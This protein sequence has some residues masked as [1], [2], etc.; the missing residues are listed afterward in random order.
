MSIETEK[1]ILIVHMN[2]RYADVAQVF[3]LLFERN[4][5]DCPFKVIY[6]YSPSMFGNFN[7]DKYESKEGTLGDDVYKIMQLYHAD[8]C[9]S[10]LGDAFITDKVDTQQF[11]Q[12]IRKLISRNF[13]Y[14]RLY[15][16]SNRTKKLANIR[17]IELYGISFIAFMCS[18]DFAYNELK[19][20]TDLDVEKKYIL[21]ARKSRCTQDV[22]RD[23]YA[24]PNTSLSIEHGIVKGKWAR[25]VYKDINRTV[26]IQTI[27]GGGQQHSCMSIVEELIY[28][29][30]LFIRNNIASPR[31]QQLFS[32]LK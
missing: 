9:I 1:W 26:N 7:N 16:S 27:R 5:P 2:K 25:K 31:I 18:Y 3:N 19:G 4:W 23:M 24:L 17:K 21:I 6:S 30:K 10:L 22:Y 15:H 11:L 20:K 14:C 29:L 28:D 32:R 13:K 8:Y 12:Q